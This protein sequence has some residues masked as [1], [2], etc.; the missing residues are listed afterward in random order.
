MQWSRKE[1]EYL[2]SIWGSNLT[3]KEIAEKLNKR[4]GTKRSKNS[5]IG[6][7]Y[8][9]DFHTNKSRSYIPKVAE[10]AWS[11][12]EHIYLEQLWKINSLSRNKLT[13]MFNVKFKS[14]RTVKQIMS[15]GYTAGFG[16]RKLRK[17]ERWKEEPTVGGVPFESI[18]QEQCK[19]IIGEP[20]NLKCCGDVIH[21]G[22]YCKK[23][24]EMCYIEGSSE[25]IV[26]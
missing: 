21:K 7:A 11:S 4:F 8:R 2:K 17:I 13:Y 18:N 6:Y 25:K 5:V 20:R 24:Y 10:V 15:Y 9:S 16:E 19:Y 3:T 23:H 14:H 26:A 12:Q 1:H 22:A